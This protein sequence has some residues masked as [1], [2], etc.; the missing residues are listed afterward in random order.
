MRQRFVVTY[1]ISDPR[2]L[3]QVFKTL[4]GFGTHLQLSV[5]S[6]DLT[7]LTL[8]KLKASLREIIDDKA[9]AV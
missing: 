1:D 4:K 7:E 5:F 6:C 8:V 3:R 2:R 9:D